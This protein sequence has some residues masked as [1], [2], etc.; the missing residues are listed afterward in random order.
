MDTCS[1]SLISSWENA[2]WK[3]I[4]GVKNNTSSTMII[5][6]RAGMKHFTDGDKTVIN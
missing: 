2:V 1:G 3:G 5:G 4:R 6:I